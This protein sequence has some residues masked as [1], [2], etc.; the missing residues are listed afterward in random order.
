M[1]YDIYVCYKNEVKF[2]EDLIKKNY[3]Q[4][5]CIIIVFNLFIN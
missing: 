3:I 2:F 5:K 1:C 4:D